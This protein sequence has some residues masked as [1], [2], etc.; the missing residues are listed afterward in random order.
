ML[1]GNALAAVSMMLFAAGFPAADMLLRDWSPIFLIAIRLAMALALL[2]PLWWVLDGSAALRKARWGRAI[3]VGGLGFGTA[4][5]LLLLAQWFTDPVTVALFAT[6]APICATLVEV[7][8]KQRQLTRSFVLGLIVSIIGGVVATGGT[9]SAELG[10][11]VGMTVIAGFGFS[12]ASNQAVRDFPDLSAV[13]RSTIT[14][15]GAGLFAVAALIVSYLAGLDVMPSTQI[16]ASQWGYLSIYAVAAMALSQILFI[17]SVGKIGVALTTFH[18]NL[19]PF[20]VMIILLSLGGD[21]NWIKA[22]GAGIVCLG[23]ILSQYRPKAIRQ[24]V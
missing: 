9:L 24:T 19:V 4:T 2:L 17:S 11:G 23:V 21:W 14:F 20:Y 7:L 1:S 18:I 15:V 16:S 5:Y 22:A 10:W 3:W 6:T 13:G 8:S 12:W